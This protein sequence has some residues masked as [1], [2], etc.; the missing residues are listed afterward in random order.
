MDRPGKTPESYKCY[1]VDR[2]VH[3]PAYF[4]KYPRIFLKAVLGIVFDSKK[5]CIYAFGMH[6]LIKRCMMKT[7]R[8]K[9]QNPAFRACLVSTD[10]GVP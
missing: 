8:V 9:P 4:F 5:L 1:E 6:R 2:C 10:F 3:F 7:R